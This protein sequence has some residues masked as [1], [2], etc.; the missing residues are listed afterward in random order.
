MDGEA[1]KKMAETV[2][3]EINNFLRWY[4]SLLS[5]ANLMAALQVRARKFFK[6]VSAVK[7]CVYQQWTHTPSQFIRVDA[8]LIGCTQ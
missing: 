4:W 6:K 5:A 3:V 2:A 7:N 8:C 1:V